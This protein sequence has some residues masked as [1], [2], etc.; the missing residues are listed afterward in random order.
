[1]LN[2][3]AVWCLYQNRQS[4]IYRSDMSEIHIISTMI[5]EIAKI[6]S[7]VSNFDVCHLITTASGMQCINVWKVSL[8]EPKLYNKPDGIIQ[9]KGGVH[10]VD[11]QSSHSL[12]ISIGTKISYKVYVEPYIRDGEFI[13]S[14]VN[15]RDQKN[16]VETESKNLYGSKYEI[17]DN[18]ELK[19]PHVLIADLPSII[20][21]E[22]ISLPPIPEPV[23]EQPSQPRVESVDSILL[24][25]IKSNNSQMLKTI[26]SASSEEIITKSIEKLPQN[27]VLNFLKMAL[28]SYYKDKE[29]SIAWIRVLLSHH[30]GYLLTVP[31]LLDI[32]SPFLMIVKNQYRHYNDFLK[33]DNRL[34]LLLALGKTGNNYKGKVVSS[35][36]PL[37]VYRDHDGEFHRVEEDMDVSSDHQESENQESE[38][39]EM[40]NND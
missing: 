9:L 32:I 23:L 16:K 28:V 37:N 3:D 35:A 20:P 26:L 31:G 10:D 11:F 33:L 7:I 21:S 15:L 8:S 30:M 19:L 36:R 38:D 12:K 14:T 2:E 27:M 22:T 4:T 40:I 13:N 5:P 29:I 39:Q 24:Q 34:E 18:I 17:F 1:V 6:N 25:A